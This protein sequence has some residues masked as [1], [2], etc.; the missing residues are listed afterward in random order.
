MQPSIGRV[1]DE[2]GQFRV[3]RVT[4]SDGT[5]IDVEDTTGDSRESYARALL[6]LDEAAAK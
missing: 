5:F 4:M 3:W 2:H 6:V 1:R